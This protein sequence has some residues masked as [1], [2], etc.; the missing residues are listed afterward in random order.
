MCYS[1]SMDIT[2]NEKKLD[3]LMMDF[4]NCTQISISIFNSDY[5][6]VS[7]GGSP[8][9]FCNKIREDKVRLKNCA[10][11][12]E[13]HFQKAKELKKTIVYTCHAGIVETIT[14]I[15]YENVII[16]YIMLGRFRDKEKKYSSASVVR[17]SLSAY[18][19]DDEEEKEYLGL[20]KLLPVLSEKQLSSAI[21]ILKTCIRYIWNEN[22]IKLNRSMLPSKIENYILENLSSELTIKNICKTFFISKE[23]LY[24]I[25]RNEY[26]DTV[27]NFINNK[28]IQQAEQLLKETTLTIDNIAESVGI[29]DYNYFIRLFKKKTGLTPLRYKK[30]FNEKPQN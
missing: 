8:Q 21:S 17:K 10:L 5:V 26:N 3:K 29:S 1:K 25:F 4:Y 2:F 20:Y 18:G 7:N 13:S 19:I 27:K 22:L 11:S 15:F 28:R 6:C 24:S 14:P 9:Q 23:T 12:D 30:V 16:A